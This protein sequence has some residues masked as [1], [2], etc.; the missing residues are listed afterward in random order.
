MIRVEFNHYGY[1]QDLMNCRDKVTS[2]VLAVI[3]RSTRNRH[4]E[5]IILRDHIQENFDFITRIRY[6][7]FIA[8]E[9]TSAMELKIS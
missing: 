4:D 1:Q 6:L 7:T 2:V 3:Y 5:S 8:A 9:E